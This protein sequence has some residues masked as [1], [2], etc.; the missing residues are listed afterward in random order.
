MID[1]QSQEYMNYLL[2]QKHDTIGA[3]CGSKYLDYLVTL[4]P[5]FNYSMAQVL[6]IGCGAFSSWEWFQERYQNQIHGCDIGDCVCDAS[7]TWPAPK[8]QSLQWPVDAH[9]L[10]RSYT[11]E[12]FDL[13]I[14]FHS[15]EHMF[16]V[17]TVLRQINNVLK[18]GG[19]FYFSL[20]MPSYNWGHGHWYDIPD[21]D[22]MIQLCKHAGF[23]SVLHNEL[24]SD[25]RFRPQQEMVALVAK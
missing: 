7:A 6:D 18:L 21:Q 1:L 19:Y 3:D 23:S 14:A 20:P 11:I 5:T 13:V 9:E 4:F 24:V 25:L 8:C 15:L 17:P 22:A 16:D 12:Q 2:D 10:L